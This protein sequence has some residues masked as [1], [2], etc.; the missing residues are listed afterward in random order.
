[1]DD[2]DEEEGTVSDSGAAKKAVRVF[3]YF[4]PYVPLK[5]GLTFLIP[6]GHPLDPDPQTSKS[7]RRAST[8]RF[9]LFTLPTSSPNFRELRRQ[10]A[11]SPSWMQTAN[12]AAKSPTS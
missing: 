8:V 11:K 4:T 9:R 6:I 10:M 3:N 7:A 1:M 5:S 12:A 2:E